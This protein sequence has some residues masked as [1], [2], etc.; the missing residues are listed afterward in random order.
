MGIDL[1]SMQIGWMDED[2]V[3]SGFDLSPDASNLAADR[4]QTVGLLV[5]ERPQA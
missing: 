2:P 1:G 5:S 3:L 4:R